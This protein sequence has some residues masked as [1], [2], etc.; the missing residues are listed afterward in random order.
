MKTRASRDYSVRSATIGSTRVAR[1]AGRAHANN[2]TI[3]TA[4]ALSASVRASVGATPYSR[5]ERVRAS[6]KAP[7]SPTS[8]PTNATVAPYRVTSRNTEAEFAPTAIR[9]ASSRVRRLTA[10]ADA[11]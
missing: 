2:V 4:I 7:S 1:H 6:A 11:P 10:Y 9:I 5:L 8:I 3:K